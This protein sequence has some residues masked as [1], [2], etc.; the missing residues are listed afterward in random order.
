MNEAL[1]A[2]QVINTCL[3][4]MLLAANLKIRGPK[5]PSVDK[6]AQEKREKLKGLNKIA[7]STPLT[8][9]ARPA[10]MED[11]VG[12]DEGIR[13]LCAALCG[14]NP[15]HIIIYGPPGV[16]KTCA[17]RL[18]LELA[19]K[20]KN[21]PFRA[22]AQFVEVDATCVRFDER[23]IADP[24][25]GSVHDPIYQ[26]AGAYGQSGIPQPKPGAVTKAH[27]GVLFLDEIGELHPM[28]MNKLLKVMEDRRVY[29]ESAYYDASDKNIPQYIH[30]IFKNGMPADFRL[31]G[32]T[33]RRPEE[34]PAALRSRAI[35]IFFKPLQLEELIT[36]ARSAARTA[37]M[38][39]E[40]DALETAA[41]CSGSGREA[42]SIVQMSASM[43]DAEG[44]SC[45]SGNDVKRV[46]EAGGFERVYRS[47]VSPKARVG[48]VNALGVA[49]SVGVLIEIEAV[50]EKTVGNG[51]LSI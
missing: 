22:E 34:L 32:A 42:V 15:Q 24:L 2:L 28:Q 29:F 17:A 43:A 48:V 21:T 45:I 19:K 1:I 41:S 9:L 13:A 51:T 46:L 26:G 12:Q 44:R 37:G 20:S 3:M 40:P 30:D 36:I 5:K 50:V 38:A 39:I 47:K 10:K 18:A 31:I 4:T 11:V 25:I 35:E 23:S 14:K 6:N 49:G 33:T 8:E 7:L 27:G 16:G